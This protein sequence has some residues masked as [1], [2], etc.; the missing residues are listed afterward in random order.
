MQT[1]I[2]RCKPRRQP[3]RKWRSCSLSCS[4]LPPRLTRARTNSTAHSLPDDHFA[5]TRLQSCFLGIDKLHITAW[6]RDSMPCSNRFVTRICNSTEMQFAKMEVKV[7]FIQKHVDPVQ[8]NVHYK[9]HVQGQNWVL[10]ES[11]VLI[12]TRSCLCTQGSKLQSLCSLC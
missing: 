8:C 7:T 9:F 12:M 11:S 2:R 5:G 1:T 10:P 6:I 4:P 3:S